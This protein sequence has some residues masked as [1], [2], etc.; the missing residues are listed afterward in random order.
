MGWFLAGVEATGTDLTAEKFAKAM[1]GVTHED[2]TTYT[3]LSFKNNHAM[4]ELVSID[5]AKGG[6]WVQIAQPTDGK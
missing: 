6:R 4:P 5:Q 1:Q 2:F 3:R